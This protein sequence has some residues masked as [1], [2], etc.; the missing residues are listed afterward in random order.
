MEVKD[1]GGGNWNGLLMTGLDDDDDDD[2]DDT[3]LS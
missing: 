1:A 3:I 2:D